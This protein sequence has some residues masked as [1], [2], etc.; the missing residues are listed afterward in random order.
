MAVLLNGLLGYGL[1]IDPLLEPVDRPP[2]YVAGMLDVILIWMSIFSVLATV[3]IAQDAIIGEK[4]SG[5]AAWVMS[6]P[7]TRG[8]YILAKFAGNAI[9]LL[10]T[11]VWAQGFLIYLQFSLREGRA[12]PVLPFF[13]A[14]LLQSLYLLFYLALTIALGAVFSSRAP[15]LAVV[16]TVLIGQ[17]FLDNLAEETA[18]EISWALPAKLPELARFAHRWEPLPS[19]ASIIIAL[20]CLSGFLAYASWRFGREEL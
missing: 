14:F 10:A 17:P 19:S 5:V 3:F 20:V 18:P 7:V 8:A 15:V 4:R 12:L 9:G 13:G 1:W 16:F 11:I 2:G 6:A